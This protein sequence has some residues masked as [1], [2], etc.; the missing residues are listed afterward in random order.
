MKISGKLL[1]G[2]AAIMFAACDNDSPNPDP[3]PN[4][5]G[6]SNTETLG[7]FVVNAGNMYNNIDGS[8]SY[9]AYADNK[10]YNNVF[11]SSN[12][13][14]KLGDTPNSGLVYEG[15]IYIAV[16]GSQVVQ[17]V[18]LDGFKFVKTISTDSYGAGPRHM[19][20]YNGKIYMTLFKGTWGISG[21]PGYLAELDPETF[22]ITRTVEVGPQPEYVVA[23]QDNLYIAVSDGYG[24]GSA[25]CVAVVDPSTFT[26]T[27]RITAT[28]FVNPVNLVTNGTKLYV[29]SWGQYLNEAP[30]TQYNYGVYE[31][32]S[33]ELSAKVC[34]GIEIAMNGDYLYYISD[35]YR[36]DGTA[37]SYG[38][39]NSATG[40]DNANWIAPGN[41][42]DYP[43][44][45]GASPITGDVFILSYSLGEGGFVS[46]DLNGYVKQY[47]P[48]GT[49]IQTFEVGIDPTGIFFTT[50]M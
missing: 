31:I 49:P 50:G 29:S 45:L 13:N 17:V 6:P 41:G 1:L 11:S 23:F 10:V 19:T 44:T 32:A 28:D 12:D 15:E 16:T 8:L 35:P 25:A 3:T 27:K 14:M 7:A 18:E 9:I 43:V 39:Y 38:V 37:P 34:D 47:K 21:E 46:Y 40:V 4:P 30:Y 42:V 26:V 5:P 24:D 22:A 48:D 2:I 33:D 36:V 20:S